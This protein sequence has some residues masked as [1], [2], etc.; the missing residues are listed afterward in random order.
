MPDRLLIISAGAYGREILNLAISVNQRRDG[1]G[2]DLGGF[3]DS[4]PDILDGKDAESYPILGSPDD[5]QPQPGDVFVCAMGDPASKTRY[6]R[7]IRERGGRFI[8]I[9]SPRASIP[10][11]TRLL[12]GCVVGPFCVLSCDQVI[13]E[14]C[15]LDAHV[16]IGHD[17]VLGRSCHLGA[18]TFVGGGA[19]IGNEALIHP[20]AMIHPGVT[21]GDGAVVGAGSVVLRDVEA[22]QTVFGNPARR[23]EA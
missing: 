10:D 1:E 22:D 8:N 2:W 5:Y 19:R 15:S 12:G 20:H 21:I 11:D 9:L 14:D 6:A 13:G 7:P 3:L 18:Y 17:A 16:T 4:R 23:V